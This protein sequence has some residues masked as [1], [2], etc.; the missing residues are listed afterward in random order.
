VA[1]TFLADA[2]HHAGDEAHRRG[3]CSLPGCPP[4]P[5]RKRPWQP[6][7]PWRRA[8][9]PASCGAWPDLMR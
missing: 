2:C 3:G 7:A 5:T 6:C 8:A 1:C 4:P 9:T